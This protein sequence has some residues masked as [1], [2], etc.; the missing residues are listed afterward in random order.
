MD[1]KEVVKQARRYAKP[2]CIKDGSSFRLKDIDPG[3]TLDLRS[4]DKPRA[5]EALATG[6]RRSPSCRTGSTRRTA[7][8]CSSSFRRWTP[9]ARTARSST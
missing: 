5:K 1:L 4:E 7:G 2:F 6:S 9:P 8:P 3:D